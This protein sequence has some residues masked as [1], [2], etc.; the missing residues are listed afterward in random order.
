MPN[1]SAIV[2]G[3]GPN[4]LAAAIELARSGLDVEV[5]EGA[6]QPGGGARSGELTL[7]GFVHDF[8]SAVHPWALISPFFSKLG[9]HAHGIRWRWSPVELAHPLDDGTAV[10]LHRSVRQTA[11][12]LGRDSAA[13]RNL[14]EP[15]VKNWRLL[16]HDVLVP[17]LHIPRHP[18][19]LARFGV[20]AVQPATFLANATLSGERAKALFM[21][22]AAHSVGNLHAPLTA[23]FGLMLGG[24]AH[25]VGWPIPVGGAQ[26]ITT[27][28][29]SVLH[30]YGGRLL[31]KT[32][33]N[34]LDE[35]QS[36][37][38]KLLDITP[39]QFAGMAG[40]SELPGSYRR[41][42]E[43]YRYGPGIY[44]VDWA[45]SEPVPWRAKDCSK[46]ITVHLGGSADE[47]AASELAAW[48]G[49]PPENPYVL[50]VQP[51]LFDPSRAPEGKHTAWAYCHVP[52]GWPG[53]A[54]QQIEDQVERFAPGFRD[55]I[56]ERTT[57]SASE[58]QD[59][60][61]NLIGGDVAGGA[62]TIKQFTLRP[63]WRYYSTPLKDVY[64]CSSSTPPGGGVH[65][66]C[67]ANAARAAL[68]GRRW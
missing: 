36:A 50:F 12:E 17:P 6:T 55:C 1:R 66:L 30:S 62:L 37:D 54:L 3:S 59:W 4:G 2:V 40:P 34:T 47:I 31:T 39:R 61:P 8:G 38:L 21:G 60:N 49:R 35:L 16:V 9:L 64:L 48:E 42:L 27:A 41:A 56:L 63:T 7:P 13:Y 28:L 14:F 5:R 19:A 58:M 51:S 29:T 45:L 15:V 52:N 22:L 53:S 18:F 11:A 68:G 10:L 32:R 43:A 23:A 25:V 24:A 20:P 67:G 26:A 65:G 57:H 33:V 46:A 44:K